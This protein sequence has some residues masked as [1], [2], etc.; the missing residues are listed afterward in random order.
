MPGSPRTSLKISDHAIDRYLARVD[1]LA[2]QSFPREA[3]RLK[4]KAGIE[5]VLGKPIKGAVEVSSSDGTFTVILR[6]DTQHEG[7]I[8]VCTIVTEQLKRTRK[9]KLSASN[10]TFSVNGLRR[11]GRTKRPKHEDPGWDPC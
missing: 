3:V 9:P 6:P 7:V 5:W 1:K 10:F 4:I 2:D 8:H 11:K